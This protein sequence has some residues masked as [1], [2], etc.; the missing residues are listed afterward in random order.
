MKFIDCFLIDHHKYNPTPKSWLMRCYKIKLT[1][2]YS[3]TVYLRLT[4]YFYARYT[5]RNNRFYLLLADFFKRKNETRNNF[6][7]GYQHNIA[8]KTLFHHTGV[9]LNNNVVIEESVQIFKDV[10]LALVEG[11]TCQIGRGSVLFSHVI[12]L[13]KKVGENCVI[14]AGSVVTTDIPDNSIAVGNPA[15]VI[16]SCVNAQDYLEFR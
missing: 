13:G 16:K 2:R 3:M 5:L 9:T 8:Y 4:E 6:E 14:G 11:K 10:T 7:H 12:I 15:R 1:Q